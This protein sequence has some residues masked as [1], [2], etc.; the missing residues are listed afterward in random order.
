[1]LGFRGTFV[2]DSTIDRRVCMTGSNGSLF[3]SVIEDHLA[4]KRKNSRLDE[5]MPLEQY[6]GDD[7]F[8]NHPLFKTEDE[9]RREEEETGEHPAVSLE[10][11]PDTLQM[12]VV[13]TAST[14]DG[15]Q[16]WMETQSETEFRWE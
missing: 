10:I 12:P 3:A 15:V 2:L 5:D 16:S 14:R 7:P 11:P 6:I 9:A 4:L 8:T 13:E 1:V